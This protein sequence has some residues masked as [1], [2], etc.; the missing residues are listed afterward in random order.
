MSKKIKFRPE[1]VQKIYCPKCGELQAKVYPW[2]NL[3]INP[4]IPIPLCKRCQNK[5]IARAQVEKQK[6]IKTLKKNKKQLPF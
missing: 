3:Q 5:E 4:E 6:L 2:G 1:K